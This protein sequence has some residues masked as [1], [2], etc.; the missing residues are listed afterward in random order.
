MFKLCSSVVLARCIAGQADLFKLA[1]QVFCQIELL[2]ADMLM[3]ISSI[4][5][6][7]FFNLQQLQGQNL[8]QSIISNRSGLCLLHQLL[9]QLLDLAWLGRPWLTLYIGLHFF[10]ALLRP[11]PPPPATHRPLLRRQEPPS[12]SHHHHHWSPVD[13]VHRR[14]T[15]VVLATLPDLGPSGPRHLLLAHHRF[16]PVDQPGPVD[17]LPLTS[18][19]DI[20]ITSDL[21][22]PS[23]YCFLLHPSTTSSWLPPS[24]FL[25]RS[26]LSSPIAQTTTSPLTFIVVRPRQWPRH[27]VGPALFVRTGRR[28]CHSGNVRPSSSY[29]LQPS[30]SSSSSSAL[31]G[32]WL[33]TIVIGHQT[34]NPS[35]SCLLLDL[36]VTSDRQLTGI[37]LAGWPWATS[38]CQ[39]TVAFK[40]RT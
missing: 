14:Q 21:V 38:T 4:R 28:P 7:P 36:V 3:V 30:S 34:V 25:R 8:D 31:L 24:S 22:C 6:S 27:V 18:C 19:L 11:S 15:F 13:I 9:Q 40:D 37:K 35:A 1:C 12:P 5:F 10:R 29:Q 17:F 33:Y 2:D 23:S 16:L 20:V 26:G 39:L 32:P